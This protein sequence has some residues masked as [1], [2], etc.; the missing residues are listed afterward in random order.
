MLKTNIYNCNVPVPLKPAPDLF[1]ITF[2][3]IPLVKMSVL[4]LDERDVPLREWPNMSKFWVL[5][6]KTQ[7]IAD[8]QVASTPN[9]NILMTYLLVRLRFRG[10]WMS[11]GID[12]G[13]PPQSRGWWTGVTLVL[14]S[15]QVY[16]SSSVGSYVAGLFHDLKDIWIW[17][18][19]NCHNKILL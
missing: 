9:G 17:V 14:R 18:I 7:D 15:T 19:T 3:M 11:H 4:C 12:S 5:A 16:Q 10:K 6:L 13:T 1:G 2:E 8:V